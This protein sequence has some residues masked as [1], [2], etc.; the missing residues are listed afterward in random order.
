MKRASGVLVLATVAL[1]AFTARSGSVSAPSGGSPASPGAQAAD[2]RQAVDILITG[3]TVITMDADRRVIEDGGVAIAGDRIVAVGPSAEIAARFRGARVIDAARKV[4]MPG[5]IDG[6]GHAGH[7]LL[8]SLGTDV[9]GEWYRACER[10]YA[11]GSTEAFWRADALLTAVERLK[12]GVTTGV[13]FF[14]GGDS[15]M[16]TD[17]PRYG[18]AHLGAVEEVGVRWVLAVGPRRPPFPRRFVHWDGDTAREVAV[19]FEDQLRTS[20]S[21]I[22]HWHRKAGGRLNIALMFPTH[23]PGTAPLGEDG[24][25]ELVRQA[26]A[27]RALS[28]KYGLLFTQDGHNRGSVKFAHEQLDLLGPDALLSHSTDLTEE[29][30]QI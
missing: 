24:H 20:E 13:T 21:L 29:E 5:L 15:V 2:G 26:K 23:H 8:K 9:P 17:D 14:G 3:G 7:G 19:S 27:T 22:Q 6:H 18:D 1:L 30:I 4:V 11:E 28:K 16:R 10:V 12:F 25:R